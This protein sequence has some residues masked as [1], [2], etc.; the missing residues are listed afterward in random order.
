MPDRVVRLGIDYGTS[1]SKIVFRDYGAPGGEKA[2]VMLHKGAFRTSSS[3]GVER[4][5]FIFGVG[6]RGEHTSTVWHESVKMRVAGEIKR[7]HPRYYRGAMNEL[8]DGFSAQNLATLT[9]W[10]LIS[11]GK[12]ALLEHLKHSSAGGVAV[13]F[14]LGIPMSFYDDTEL[15]SAF[16]E[17]ARVAWE[18]SKFMSATERVSFAEARRALRLGYEVVGNLGDLPDEEV[19]H[20]VR[21]EA[22][23]ALW[24]PFQSPSV[25]DGPYA[26][27][28][29]GAGTA[30]LALFRIVP[31]HTETGWV[32]ASLSFFGAVSPPVGMDAIDQAITEWRGEVLENSFA[33]R[34]REQKLLR[35]RVGEQ[36]V[37]G[38]VKEL[39][40]AYRR[41]LLKAFVTHLQSRDERDNW[42][43]HQIFFLGGGSEVDAI[44]NLLQISPLP[45]G[46]TTVHETAWLEKPGDLLMA[47]QTTVPG[48]VMPHV[49][50]AYGLSSLAAEIPSSETPSETPPMIAIAQY[51][52]IELDDWRY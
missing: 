26:Q 19:R 43:R 4:D 39:R 8:P 51:Q 34:G 52:R 6:P 7:D 50:V 9:V 46:E 15:K 20:W 45:G 12:R 2:Y 37:A 40:A 13:G 27:I 17:I 11:E 16:V 32:K 44:T 21:T 42:Y 29:I 35:G 23:A 3:V 24:W 31:R 47:D 10:F 36:L 48:H 49:A 14:S 30:N 25:R 33:M 22:E 1:F 38:V 28:D 5:E 41:T 18:I